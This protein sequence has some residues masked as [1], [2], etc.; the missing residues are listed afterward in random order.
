ME[1]F[2]HISWKGCGRWSWRRIVKSNVNTKVQVTSLGG[3]RL[4]K[5]QR[6]FDGLLQHYVTKLP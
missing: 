4:F 2:C 1:D 3:D 6:V 5:M